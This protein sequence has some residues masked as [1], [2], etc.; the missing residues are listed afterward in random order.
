MADQG[1]T[2]LKPINF[3]ALSRWTS[4]SQWKENPPQ[5]TTN[6]ISEKVKKSLEQP[7]SKVDLKQYKSARESEKI[8]Q[9][10][11]T[12]K[13][14]LWY[15]NKT[16]KDLET[17]KA[18]L[19]PEHDL[20]KILNNI[21]ERIAGAEGKFQRRGNLSRKDLSSQ[22]SL[23]I[24]TR[25]NVNAFTYKRGRASF[26]EGGFISLFDTYLREQK[27]LLGLSEDHLACILGHE[28]S[29]SDPEAKL[30]YLNEEYC[31]VQGALLTAEA[32]YNPQAMLDTEDFLIW[33]DRGGEFYQNANKSEMRQEHAILSTHPPSENRKLTI[34]NVLKNSEGAIPNQTKD[35]TYIDRQHIEDL[36][37]IIVNWT[38][39]RQSSALPQTREE[40]LHNI[41][42]STNFTELAE[43]IA[44][45]EVIK[46]AETTR[47][48]AK[49]DR[50]I[51]L[52]TLTR[53]M[54]DEID[55]AIK[56]NYGRNSFINYTDDPSNPLDKLADMSFFTHNKK[57]GLT[58]DYETSDYLIGRVAKNLLNDNQ[59]SSDTQQAVDSTVDMVTKELEKLNPKIEVTKT[60]SYDK[61][62]MTEKE[63]KL[64]QDTANV[65]AK[66]NTA[67]LSAKAESLFKFVYSYQGTID[68]P[69]VFS[70]DYSS[71]SQLQPLLK[72]LG[73]TDFNNYLDGLK[74]NF[75]KFD[76]NQHSKQLLSERGK[77]L[78]LTSK[79]LIKPI[80]ELTKA[81][82]NWLLDETKEVRAFII[83]ETRSEKNNG[84]EDIP[85]FTQIKD[86]ISKTIDKLAGELTTNE[87]ERELL[88]KQLILVIPEPFNINRRPSEDL[89][90]SSTINNKDYNNN[91]IEEF[92][93]GLTDEFFNLRIKPIYGGSIINDL[94]YSSYGK[95]KRT[96]AGI[97]DLHFDNV[98]KEIDFIR[99]HFHE[100]KYV[101]NQAATPYDRDYYN[102]VLTPRD[103]IDQIKLAQ[104][105][106]MLIPTYTDE[107]IKESYGETK[108]EV[109]DRALA[110]SEDRWSNLLDVVKGF[111][112]EQ[113]HFEKIILFKDKPAIEKSRELLNLVEQG[114]LT[115]KQLFEKL[116]ISNDTQY[117]YPEKF[118]HQITN[119]NSERLEK[120][121]ISYD[122][123]TELLKSIPVSPVPQEANLS[124]F[125]DELFLV[126]KRI[127][128]VEKAIDQTNKINIS[129]NISKKVDEFIVTEQISLF[130][131]MTKEEKAQNELD[132]IFD[133]TKD[134]GVIKLSESWDGLTNEGADV[135]IFRVLKDLD[136]PLDKLKPKVETVISSNQHRFT[137]QEIDKWVSLVAYCQQPDII[138]RF[139]DKDHWK[140]P[141]VKIRSINN[142]FIEYDLYNLDHTLQIADAIEILPNST[143]KDHCL[144]QF[145]GYGRQ[146]VGRYYPDGKGG[147]LFEEHPGRKVLEKRILSLLTTNFSPIS[148]Q[149]VENPTTSRDKQFLRGSKNFIPRSEYYLNDSLTGFYFA[150]SKAAGA[151][152]SLINE[153]D[154]LYH[155]DRINNPLNFNYR[156]EPNLK[157]LPPIDRERK[158]LQDRLD[159]L[160]PITDSPVKESLVLYCLRTAIE[161]TS[162]LKESDPFKLELNETI[163]KLG[164][165][166]KSDQGRRN[167]FDLAFRLE[168]N[169]GLNTNY[170]ND[171]VKTRFQSRQ[172]L[173]DYVFTF[174]PNKSSFRDSYLKLAVDT[175]PLRVK[176][177]DEVRNLFFTNDY[178]TN[179]EGLNNERAGLEFL[180]SVKENKNVT[181]KEIRELFLW[182]FDEDRQIKV[183]DN[184]LERIKDNPVGIKLVEGLL[185][186]IKYMPSEKAAE[187]KDDETRPIRDRITDYLGDRYIETIT[188][189]LLKA[190]NSVKKI[191]IKRLLEN[192]YQA[193]D[194]SEQSAI[195][196]R[197]GMPDIINKITEGTFSSIIFGKSTFNSLLENTTLDNPNRR[198]IFFD[199][200]LG[201]RGILEEPIEQNS[202]T[203]QE[204]FKS[205]F[206]GSE[207]HRFVDDVLEV[208]LGKT[209]IDKK[210][211]RAAEVVCH[212]FIEALDPI[213][214]ADVM[215]NLLTKF[216]QLDLSDPNPEVNQ[217]KL[218][219]VALSSIGVVGAKIGQIDELIPKGWGSSLGSLKHSTKPLSKL[220]VADIFRQD[221]LSDEYVIVDSAGAASTACGY[222]VQNPNN[223]SEFSKV[224]R[225]EVKIEWKK[226]FYAIRYMLECLNT[227]NL[228][229][230][231]S[232]PIMKQLEKLIEE[233]LK[234]QKE[235]DNVLQY[236]HAETLAEREKRGGIRAVEMPKTRIGQDGSP[237]EAKKDSLII[238]EELLPKNK[239]IELSKLKSTDG[240]SF[241]YDTIHETIIRDFF[242]RAFTLGSWH[243]DLHDGNILVSI[244]GA[245]TRVISPND[246][247]LI[248]FGQTGSVAKEENKINSAKF[249]MGLALKDRDLVAEALT[250]SLLD[251]SSLTIEKVKKELGIN[252]SKLQKATTEFMSA[253]EI[254]PYLTN[255]MKATVNVLPYLRP[256]PRAKQFELI[257][258]Y[259]QETDRKKLWIRAQEAIAT[260]NYTRLFVS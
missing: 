88:K 117:S 90:T 47:A 240:N 178:K 254:A 161:E 12:E 99:S 26:F 43:A 245:T 9:D 159:F 197:A 13:E 201:I 48:I 184:Y 138:N 169:V 205:H 187:S 60:I 196:I 29:H 83:T 141:K 17:Q 76:I 176:D 239:Y 142:I 72:D 211:R 151:F 143:Y 124:E 244:N 32:G 167:I 207:M 252:P 36:D 172:E 218:L 122:V 20:S 174:L 19:S 25:D 41:E 222:V 247:V 105:R 28:A 236:V 233:E 103:T 181:K 193:N 51:N 107:P 64:L 227:T 84:F 147:S 209:K 231:N 191:I 93:S 150:N 35:Y 127:I 133:F 217:S 232:G 97:V 166:F 5:I 125:C 23:N 202:S 14:G 27:H 116:I 45:Y 78:F 42:S 190:P 126:K 156:K 81:D 50:L 132:L 258:P 98:A 235:V 113:K 219:Q 149:L 134:G 7:E 22:Y 53:A 195:L 40:V 2:E 21:G 39:G 1:V 96:G 234:T 248:D 153:E 121:K 148:L 100:G 115:F 55:L 170:E 94:F 67:E 177:A 33:L 15:A 75:Q 114:K 230:A 212:S 251:R 131:K 249:F 144:T 59:L 160:K 183:A 216:S 16:V 129:N 80:K 120:L 200:T 101:R 198:E 68:L 71:C 44:G 175:Y 11:N 221:G 30:G 165:E 188:T 238:L 92:N 89:A 65:E 257:S 119:W 199:L 63:H 3:D 102:F 228:L 226:D 194:I 210:S 37:Q 139:K 104:K 243:T 61:K 49:N 220:T 163:K 224:V 168:L 106:M 171:V 38:E 10:E 70:G 46:R 57:R 118:L 54:T 155:S 179:E 123:A 242:H 91:F 74:T 158:I 87:N 34:I 137:Q 154:S 77:Q 182:L 130:E 206:K 250:D 152:M 237:I 203:F 52:A 213:K 146:S 86:Q 259:I 229:K 95:N 173:L 241:D 82:I 18:L 164:K 204:R 145:L 56:K 157:L 4:R 185:K 6:E 162:H 186:Q 79:E 255:F 112:F 225:P 110:S 136:Y 253:H 31:D 85:F 215:Y 128:Q 108:L 66:K 24:S 214:R 192:K 73:V 260:K 109:S 246:L 135:D 140:E 58:D 223:E 208:A 256:L 189:S 111:D 180:K 69:A 62:E 8:F